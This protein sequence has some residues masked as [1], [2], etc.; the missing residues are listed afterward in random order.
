MHSVEA[1][2]TKSR[3]KRRHRKSHGRISF[4]DLARSIA[5][6]WKTVSP[7]TKTI[8][9]H[10]AERDMLRY[11]RELKV[12]KDMKDLEHEQT[13]LAKHS[14]FM[15][16]MSSIMA[17]E[18]STS[19]YLERLQEEGSSTHSGYYNQ[20]RYSSFGAQHPDVTSFNSS[21]SSLDSHSLHL[22]GADS[23]P[24][25]QML[26]RQ[27]QI[28]QEQLMFDNSTS[29]VSQSSNHTRVSMPG[30]GVGVGMLPPGSNA[31]H[32]SF[33]SFPAMMSSSGT[34]VGGSMPSTLSG[35]FASGMKGP[36]S[37]GGGSMHGLPLR[38]QQ[39]LQLRKQQEQRMMVSN[40]STMSDNM[41]KSEQESAFGS[42]GF[43]HSDVPQRISSMMSPPM[44]M[45]MQQQQHQLQEMEHQQSI[46]QIQRQMQQQQ[47]E[48]QMQQQQIKI[49][50]QHQQQAFAAG[51]CHASLSSLQMTDDGLLGSTSHTVS[52]HSNANQNSFSTFG[53]ASM[54]QGLG[55]GSFHGGGFAVSNMSPPTLGGGNFQSQPSHFNNMM[56][57]SSIQQLNQLQQNHPS[58]EQM[59]NFGLGSSGTI[60]EQNHEG[61]I[62][63]MGPMGR[64][65]EGG[66]DMDGSER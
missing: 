19:E 34:G 9:E 44:M 20:G 48:Q 57:R 23:E 50:M 16:S 25:Q 11:K 47:Q 33:S 61:N 26:L 7:N 29:M 8:F 63:L 6:S 46:F 53:H 35:S 45:M 39:Q 27:Q 21:M 2:L 18:S 58:T 37:L 4:G 12:W 38:Q 14:N 64:F 56:Q 3:Q 30:G 60:N 10:Y 55:S 13:T 41:G 43:V 28:L 59:M 40:N 51:I 65:M 49:Q 15:N 42:S 22:S 54:N 62:H 24:M 17:S 5:D 66:S 36:G 52:D 31:F 32:A 1:I